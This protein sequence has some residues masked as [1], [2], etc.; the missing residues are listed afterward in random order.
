MQV[1]L[2]GNKV[3]SHEKSQKTS[4]SSLFKLTLNIGQVIPASIAIKQD[5]CANTLVPTVNS[6]FNLQVRK[7][8][9]IRINEKT[10]VTNIVLEYFTRSFWFSSGTQLERAVGE[11]GREREKVPA[12]F[13]RN[14]K[15]SSRRLF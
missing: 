7:S 12:D 1:T 13:K 4:A 6:H 11:G 10:P 8:K 3:V 2:P 15:N 9:K 5:R 14:T